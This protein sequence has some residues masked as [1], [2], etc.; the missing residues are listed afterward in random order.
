[1]TSFFNSVYSE[2]VSVNIPAVIFLTILFLSI[3]I[4]WEDG[5]NS[6]SNFWIKSVQVV[7]FL[8]PLISM[9][10]IL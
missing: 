1:M 7:S 5:F 3:I 9:L 4:F 8:I 6:S 2:L 10:I